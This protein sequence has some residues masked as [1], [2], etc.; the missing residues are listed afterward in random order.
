MEI[1]DNVYLEE[2][3]NNISESNEDKEIVRKILFK[4]EDN[5]EEVHI[6]YYFNVFLFKVSTIVRS[7]EHEEVFHVQIKVDYEINGNPIIDDKI[8]NKR[9]V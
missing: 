3:E 8:Q 6:L 5:I 7:I 2:V 4:D 1:K 9:D